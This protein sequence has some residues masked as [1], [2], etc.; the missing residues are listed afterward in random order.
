M[1]AGRSNQVSVYAFDSIRSSPN[2][3]PMSWEELP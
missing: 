2:D 3:A 1:A